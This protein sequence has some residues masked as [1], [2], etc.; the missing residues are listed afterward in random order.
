MD[1]PRIMSSPISGRLWPSQVDTDSE[2]SQVV[3]C[4]SVVEMR[5]RMERR[6]GFL[7]QQYN[8]SSWMQNA[9]GG[10]LAGP[11]NAHS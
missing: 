9:N 5:T 7:V 2:L 6:V 8:W 4:L 3:L 1:T 10:R 11:P